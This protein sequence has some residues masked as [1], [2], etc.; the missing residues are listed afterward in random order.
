MADIK[1]IEY[2]N[3]IWV[4]ESDKNKDAHIVSELIT[5]EDG[6]TDKNLRIHYDYKRPFYLTK[7]FYRD[8]KQ[9]KEYEDI[10][11][12]DKYTSTQSQLGNEVARKLGRQGYM[13]NLLR[14][15][16]DS[17]YL[18]MATISSTVIMRKE[19]RRRYEPLYTPNHYMALDIENSV[20]TGEISVT[21]MSDDDN[22]YVYINHNEIASNFPKEHIEKRIPEL[23]ISLMDGIDK[24]KSTHNTIHTTDGKSFKLHIHIVRNEKEL[25]IK[26]IEQAHSTR[27]DILAAW[28]KH[29]WTHYEKRCIVNGLDP[30]DV[31][32]DPE[33][34]PELRRFKINIGNSQRVTSSGK[35]LNLSPHEVWSTYDSTSYFKLMDAMVM[36]NY[37]RAGEKNV[38][39]GYNLN[40]ILKVH[41]KRTKLELEAEETKYMAGADKHYWLSKNK[42]LEYIVYNMW[43]ARGMVELD[44]KTQ[45]LKLSC[46]LLV[47]DS[48][49][50][51]YNSGPK[52]LQDSYAF[53]VQKYGKV[54]GVHYANRPN[55]E[56]LSSED[57]IVTLNAYKKDLERLA[58][59]P[60]TD[61]PMLQTNVVTKVYD[62]D[63][64][65]SYPSQTLVNNI[66]LETLRKELLGVEGYDKLYVQ[67]N[68]IQLLEGYSGAPF[69][70][71]KFLNTPS[72][73]EIAKLAA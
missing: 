20:L 35:T 22:L 25:I 9:K 61:A 51:N 46:M 38:A 11:K 41:L 49:Y 36:Y 56:I 53:F 16:Q 13:R 59:K 42:P 10:K 48:D 34:P 12:V 43:D 17:P 4:K 54:L 60:Y 26:S 69:W 21:S 64:T 70:C 30:A 27:P 44:N 68:N 19:Y 57:W 47:G 15:S 37:T 1:C 14:D 24:E 28:S 67:R 32:S 8:H 71:N 29:D 65:S 63:L 3:G 6:T 72:M 66:S 33:V 18:Y 23:Y 62:R 55:F 2:R 5:Y 31:F 40:N 45:D 39:G 7:E 50:N 73:S 52:K 58:Q